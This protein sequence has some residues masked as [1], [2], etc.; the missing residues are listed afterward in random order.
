MKRLVVLF[1]FLLFAF[2][3]CAQDVNH[4]YGL[5]KITVTE[6]PTQYFG[7]LFAANSDGAW[8]IRLV[9]ESKIPWMIW[10]DWKPGTMEIGA[11]SYEPYVSGSQSYARYSVQIITEG[12]QA[13]IFPVDFSV[14][15]E[16]L[17]NHRVI[18]FQKAN[19]R[20]YYPTSCAPGNFM[21]T[22]PPCVADGAIEIR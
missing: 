19:L 13:D 5:A 17:T 18:Q 22:Q 7:A 6:G 10:A 14:Q 21:I 1:A 11:K 2:P 9:S 16:L 20:P 15:S 4:F 3:L 8:T 12:F